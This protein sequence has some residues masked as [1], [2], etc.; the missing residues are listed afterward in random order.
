[1]S[2]T[3]TVLGLTKPA[4]GDR[5]W[6]TTM[7]A[8][9]DIIDT[10]TA[11]FAISPAGGTFTDS[12]ST[13]LLHTGTTHGVKLAA[14]NTEL[15]GFHGATP[16]VQSASANQAAIGTYATTTLTDS[17]GGT[18]TT[19]LALMTNIAT[20]TDSTGGTASTTLAAISDT[21]TK[22]AVASIAAQTNAQAILNIRYINAH[23]SLA[24]QVNNVVAD[25]ATIKTLVNQLRADLVAKGIIKGS[26]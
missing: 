14:Y 13:V 5:N 9:L 17:T 26:S 25:L 12:A 24:A 4:A 11:S 19:T 22:N 7:N 2:T 8:N 6:G 15:L 21:A 18:P 3:T 1:M 23:S 16:S 10:I 20:V